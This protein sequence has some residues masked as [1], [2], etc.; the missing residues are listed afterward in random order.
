[1][2]LLVE[3]ILSQPYITTSNHFSGEE[4]SGYSLLK[5][6]VSAG[7]EYE[8]AERVVKTHMHRTPKVVDLVLAL[9]KR[10]QAY[11]LATQ[12]VERESVGTRES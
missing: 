6:V 10:G 3:K 5:D 11:E 4:Y 1:M 7:A 8:V 2:S 9:V 12:I